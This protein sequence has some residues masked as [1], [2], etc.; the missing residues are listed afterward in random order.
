M[1]EKIKLQRKPYMIIIRDGWGHNPDSSQD[2]YNAIKQA[3][4]PNDDML[5]SQYPNCLVETSGEAVGLPDGTM[6]NS[7][8]GHQN[9][10][11][12]RIVYQESVRITKA[13]REGDFF[14]NEH[15][16]KAIEQVKAKGT[17]FHIMG[18]CSD[19]GVHSLLDHLYGLL[20]LCKR[21]NVQEVYLHAFT[22]GRDSPPTSGKD[23]LT[24]IQNK[25]KEIGIGK[26]ASIS[27][28]FYAM[29][30]DKRW[31][32]VERAY[33]C[34]TQGIGH[35]APDPIQALE[36]SYEKDITDEFIEPVNIT[37]NDKPVA[38][39]EDGDAVVF[40]N[41]RG[42]R[43]R[44]ISHAFT[45]KEFKEFDRKVK[46]DTYFICMTQYDASLQAEVAFPKMPKM[47]NIAG[48]YWSQL[49][50]KQ[51]RCAE[52]EK[53]AHVTFF[54]NDYTEEAFEGEDR[55]I[56]PSP[57]VRTYDMK[58]EM[59]AF[60]V[61]DTVLEKLDQNQHDIYVINF[62]NPDMVGHTGDLEAAKIA[63]QTV[64][65]CVGDILKKL[66][67]LGGVALIMADHGN[68]EKMYD[69]GNKME[70]TA[71]TIGKVPF[72]IYDPQNKNIKLKDEGALA[73]VVPTLLDMMDIPKPQEMTGESLIS[74]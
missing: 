74:K 10:G 35:K 49:G 59:S 19:I 51:F 28:R 26:V 72:I 22:D 47:K 66:E 27:G 37:E 60:E 24:E 55:Q 18:L 62:A 45:D 7:E 58:P 23:Y 52:T 38:L 40:F 61:R 34:L 43:P 25:M 69:S 65:T 31:D 16:L 56:I 13:I 32:R 41:F 46:T 42:D 57:K 15:F 9:I 11:A 53:Y 33:N 44:E 67:T 30:R 68:F 29:D 39:I 12:G 73:D 71:H 5:M 8:V 64:D 63:A 6:G 50:L 17:K 2:A 21:N 48:Q 70:H 54:F 20:E 3:N 1:T 14:E 4:T 36:Q